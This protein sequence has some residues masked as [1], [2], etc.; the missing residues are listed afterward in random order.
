MADET[1]DATSPAPATP[2]AMRHVRPLARWLLAGFLVVAGTG[3][4]VAHEEFLAQTPTWVPARTLVVWGS[5]VIE[6][7]L[8]LALLLVCR[9][10]RQLGWVVAVFFVLVFPGNVH[11]AV[12]GT[13]AFGLDTPAARWTR[14]LFQPLLIAWALWSTRE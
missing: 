10:R 6:I 9:R 8:G 1:H 3:H 14:L 7:A 4:L 5:G 13:D 12:A 2:A 11:Q